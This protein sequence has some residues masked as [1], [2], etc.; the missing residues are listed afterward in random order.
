MKDIRLCAWRA[1]QSNICGNHLT[2]VQYVTIGSQVKFIDT[3]KYYQQ[4][5][6][7]LAKSANENEKANTRISLQ[8]FIEKNPTYSPVCNSLLDENKN[9]VLDYL[10]SGKE[11]I[12]YEVA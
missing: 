5:L 11:S 6:S 7:S 10:C 12:L 4:L 1:T 2:N 8:K 9:W 3:I